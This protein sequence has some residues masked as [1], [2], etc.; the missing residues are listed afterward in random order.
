MGNE[1][2]QPDETHTVTLEFQKNRNPQ[3]TAKEWD[4]FKKAILDLAKKYKGR[5]KS[6]S[7]DKDE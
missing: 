5:I 6:M 1:P 2:P 4:D 3:W 7:Y